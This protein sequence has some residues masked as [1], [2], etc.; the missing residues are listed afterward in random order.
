MSLLEN[1]TEDLL[2][3]AAIEIFEELGYNYAFGPDIAFDGNSP[4]RNNYKDVILE[5]RVKDALFS[6]N[7]HLPEEA[8]EEAYRKIITFNSPVL[9][10]NNKAFHKLLV[11]GIDV[12]FSKDGEIKTEK[13]Y[14]IDFE[15]INKNDFLVV[16]QFTIIEKEERRPDLV[17]FING[18]P[19]VVIELKSASDENVGI[20]EAYNQIQT[21]KNDI[22][23]L[24]NY[25][26]FCILSM[27]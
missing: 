18:I 4:E 5:Q 23:S 11:E 16:N 3:Q 27:V 17:L 9:V 14:I 13:A 19:L 26:A 1:F 22:P 12:S 10:E 21:Y 8:L 2:E 6:I 25:N 7:R 20:E 24:F 15:N